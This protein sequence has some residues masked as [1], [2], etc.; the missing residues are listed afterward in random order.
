[1]LSKKDFKAANEETVKIMLWVA[2]REKQGYLDD[3]DIKKF[4][5]RDLRTIDKLWLTYSNGKFGFSVQKQIWIECG[6]KPGQYNWKTMVKFVKNVKWNKSYD[7]L[8]WDLRGSRGHLPVPA[9]DAYEMI[10]EIMDLI[11]EQ[12]RHIDEVTRMR[13]DNARFNPALE[14]LDSAGVASIGA[15]DDLRKWTIVRFGWKV[16]SW[17]GNVLGVRVLLGIISRSETCKLKD[18][19]FLPLD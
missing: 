17:W 14:E 5:C 11:E 9:R 19:D 12:F 4:P 18:T 10:F 3:D 7:N 6:A 8:C 1:M 15:F 2:R 16:N 13:K